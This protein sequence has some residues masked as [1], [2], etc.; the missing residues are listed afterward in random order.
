[1]ATNLDISD[2]VGSSGASKD[3]HMSL[4]GPFEGLSLDG[5][6]KLDLSVV[7]TGNGELSVHGRIKARV[8]LA[9]SRCAAEYSESLDIDVDER[10]VPEGS[11][12]LERDEEIEADELC[13]FGYDQNELKIDELTRENII[14]SLPYRPLCSQECRGV[15][16]Q[17]GQNLNEKTCM[18][19][20]S[21]EEI[22]P[23][24][25]ALKKFSSGSPNE[26]TLK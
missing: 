15:C 14:A 7:S 3:V 25:G 13:V 12:E 16:P 9:C 6:A 10:F 26:G 18:C 1:M 8:F 24:W 4:E 11:L 23:R 17:C 22:D 19:G 21:E 20:S 2:I 5:P